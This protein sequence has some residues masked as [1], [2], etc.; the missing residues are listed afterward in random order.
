MYS[1]LE[2]IENNIATLEISVSPEKLEE[3]IMKSYLK[4]VKKFNIAGFRRGKAPRKIIE[5]HYGEAV[6]YEDA[7]NIVCPEAYD[8]AV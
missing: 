6:F 1:K 2:K 8:E 7:I 5:M 4:N 3:G